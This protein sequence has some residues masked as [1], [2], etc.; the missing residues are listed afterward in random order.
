MA[1]GIVDEPIL[2]QGQD[3]LEI[4]KHADALVS[5]LKET[6]TPMTIG[7]QGSGEVEKLLFSTRLKKLSSSKEIRQIWI[8]SWGNS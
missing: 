1:I 3:W 6:D 8:N 5:F 7:V 2:G 4:K